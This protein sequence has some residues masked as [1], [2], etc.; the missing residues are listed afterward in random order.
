MSM[1]WKI[2][3]NFLNKMKNTNTKKKLYI[4][5]PLTLLPPDKKDAFLEMISEIKKELKN[6]FEILEFL[7]IADL[8][9]A[10][11]FSPKEI[12]D[13]DI[14][15]CV[16]KADCMLAICD[17]PSI[18]LG[19]EMATAMEKQNIPVLAVAKKNSEISRLIRGIDHKNFSFM[20]YNTTKDIVEK[21]LLTILKQVI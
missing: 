12:Y 16:L 15:E 1:S 8:G 4:G 13:W 2:P 9:S 17:Y 20:Y 18:S 14:K 7:G 21:T 11:P 3:I 19:Y 5:C 6:H 10:H